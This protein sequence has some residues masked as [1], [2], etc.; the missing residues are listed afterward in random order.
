MKNEL[1]K[2]FEKELT[3]NVDAVGFKNVF[4]VKRRTQNLFLEKG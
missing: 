3:E 2:V 1:N 4:F